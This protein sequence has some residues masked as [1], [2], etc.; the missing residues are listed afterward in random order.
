M[1]TVQLAQAPTGLV[2]NKASRNLIDPD[3]RTIAPELR[4]SALNLREP[5]RW[6]RNVVVVEPGRV[7][8]WQWSEYY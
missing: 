1:G 7:E 3:T 2:C 4:V 5:S 8:L 6:E